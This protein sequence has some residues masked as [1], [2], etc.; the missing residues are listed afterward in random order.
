MSSGV[1]PP[2]GVNHRMALRHVCDVLGGADVVW[3]LTGS[4]AFALRGMDVVPHDVDIQTDAHGAYA[5][6]RILAPYMVW[7]VRYRTALSI[8][9]HFG[10]ARVAGVSVEIMGAIET[11]RADGSWTP[12]V[13]LRLL[14]EWVEWEGRA[15]PVLALAHEIAAYR[16]LGREDRAAWLERMRPNGGEADGR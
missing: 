12:P 6:E 11:R 1:G 9:S 15:W 4:T 2:L 10:R 7:P 3:A 8:R 5:I 13:D 16:A 14:V